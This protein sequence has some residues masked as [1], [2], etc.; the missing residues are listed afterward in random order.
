MAWSTALVFC[1]DELVGQDPSI[2][3]EGITFYTEFEG[4]ARLAKTF[5]RYVVVTVSAREFLMQPRSYTKITT[6]HYWVNHEAGVG[7][8]ARTGA[9]ILT[10]AQARVVREWLIERSPLAWEK[11]APS[12]KAALEP[13]ACGGTVE[14]PTVPP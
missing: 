11:A 7:W 5:T 12:V 4:L 3:T 6:D 10:E 13:P 14:Q 2:V 1:G 8:F 9:P